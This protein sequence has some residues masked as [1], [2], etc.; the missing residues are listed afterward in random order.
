[1]ARTAW[2]NVMN[3]MCEVDGEGL[4]ECEM[5]Q[6]STS[7]I[8]QRHLFGFRDVQDIAP[9]FVDDAVYLTAVPIIFNSKWTRRI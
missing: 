1:M 7:N 5:S 3:R 6:G 8:R 9:V 4:G 2:R